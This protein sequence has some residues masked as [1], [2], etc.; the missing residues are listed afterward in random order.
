VLLV[1]MAIAV[2]IGISYASFTLGTQQR[3]DTKA[4]ERND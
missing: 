4:S 2:I 1:I 3:N